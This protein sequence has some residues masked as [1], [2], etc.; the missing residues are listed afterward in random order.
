MKVPKSK[1][2][3]AKLPMEEPQVKKRIML[4]VSC[5]ALFMCAS[6]ALLASGKNEFVFSQDGR[7][8]RATQAPSHI[9]PAPPDDANLK[10]IAG[11]FSTYP[12]AT[13]FSIWGETIDQG[14]NDYP[15]QTWAAMAF[16]PTAD[17]TV[18]KIETSAGRQSSGTAGLELGLYSDAGGVPGK[19]IKSFHVSK[20]PVY[21]QCCAVSTANDKAGIPVKAGTQYW[22]VVSTTPKDTDIYAWAF[23]STDMRPHLG[24]YWCKGSSQYCQNSGK[25]VPTNYVQ[26]GFAVLGR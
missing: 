24:A 12:N 3:A 11:N 19:A 25:W 10:T 4:S 8:V 23:N 6:L 16:T 18:T 14:V 15:F 1:I 22:V 7:F 5:L 9:T 13:Y 20:L 17:A 21:G 26:F 2:T